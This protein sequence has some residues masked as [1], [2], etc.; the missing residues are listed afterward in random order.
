MEKAIEE[1]IKDDILADFLREHRAEARNVSIF[2]YDEE[3]HM[4]QIREEGKEEALELASHILKSVQ[5][6]SNVTNEELAADC[7]ITIEEVENLRTKFG[8]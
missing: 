3:L 8:L 7:Q 1:C 5:T 4:K 6:H 2:E